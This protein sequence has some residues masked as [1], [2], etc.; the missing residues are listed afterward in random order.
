MEAGQP[1]TRNQ[2]SEA[3]QWEDCDEEV[4][5]R[6]VYGKEDGRSGFF[7]VTVYVQRDED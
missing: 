2:G 3:S 1:G 7:A 6:A 4:Q 5:S